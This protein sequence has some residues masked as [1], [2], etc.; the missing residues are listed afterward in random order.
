MD[1]C[2][3]FCLEQHFGGFAVFNKTAYFRKQSAS[4]CY[5][6]LQ[7]TTTDDVV[8]W[9]APAQKVLV[10]FE[11]DKDPQELRQKEPHDAPLCPLA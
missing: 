4:E 10:W 1:F 8:F 6:N 7:R 11:R 5:E 3:T 2:K 9:I